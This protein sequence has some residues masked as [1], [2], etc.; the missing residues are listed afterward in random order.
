MT[1]LLK[2]ETI[3]PVDLWRFTDMDTGEQR[4]P[5]SEIPD[6]YWCEQSA[7]IGDARTAH[8]RLTQ[9]RRMELDDILVRRPRLFRGW[10]TEIA[11]AHDRLDAIFNFDRF[12]ESDEPPNH[13]IS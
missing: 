9:M 8:L 13:P 5:N 4:T 2:F 10:W 12:D 7:T 3:R 11:V 1:Y 6:E